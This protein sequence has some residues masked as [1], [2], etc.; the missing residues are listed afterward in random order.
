M[1]VLPI[2]DGCDVV[3]EAFEAG[4]GHGPD[5]LFGPGQPLAAIEE[6]REVELARAECGVRCCGAFYVTI[7]REGD[8]VVW[9]KWRDDDGPDLDLPSFRFDATAY[10]AEIER[11]AED[12]GWE[13]PARV[14]ARLVAE[15]F[16]AEPGA[17]AAWECGFY[18]AES[19]S[20]RRDRI[21]VM[22]FYP[23]RPVPGRPFLQ[24]RTE[25]PVTDEDP[26]VQAAR[27]F[28]DL[29]G[30]DPRERADVSGGSAE[31]ARTLGYPWPAEV[32][33]SGLALPSA[34]LR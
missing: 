10:V 19:W 25:R 29:T 30:A 24:F 2:I 12:R 23:G 7:R 1:Q 22:F 14:V 8:V 13:W 26:A 34:R 4:P 18:A 17:L 15:R 21:I 5:R 16:H 20:W 6:P 31:Y 11:A 32:P 27:L 33:G 9:E 28:A 3:G